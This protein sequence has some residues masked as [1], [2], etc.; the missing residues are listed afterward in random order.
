MGVVTLG[1]DLVSLDSLLLHLTEGWI[2]QSEKVF[3][4]PIEMA[5][6]ELGSYDREIIEEARK[7]MGSWLS[8]PPG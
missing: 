6:E 5:Q 2:S 1:R 7:K 4:A 3:S 8:P